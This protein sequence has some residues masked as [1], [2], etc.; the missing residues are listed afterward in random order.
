MLPLAL[1]LAL[2]AQPSVQPTAVVVPIRLSGLSGNESMGLALQVHQA[3]SAGGVAMAMDP[4]TALARLGVQSEGAE[5][6]KDSGDCPVALGKKLGVA[7]VIALDATA[8][9]KSCA[10]H[11]EGFSA[12]DGARLGVLDLMSPRDSLKPEDK[13]ALQ[14]FAQQLAPKLAALARPIPPTDL[15]REPDLRPP[16]TPSPENKLVETAPPP[17][18]R[19]G[20]RGAVIGCGVGAGIAAAA[21]IA[22]GVVGYTKERSYAPEAGKVVGMSYAKAQDAANQ[23]NV[24]YGSAGGAAGVAAIL[25]TVAVVLQL[26]D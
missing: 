23:A 5:A 11:L 17:P 25:A 2:G 1:L 26:S 19:S 10:L 8:G 12:E 18:T 14:A 7:A 20:H 24:M 13:A 9:R 22:L 6:C 15:P 21:A 3:L 16:P 4:A